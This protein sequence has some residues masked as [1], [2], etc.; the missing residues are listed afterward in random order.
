M[1]P[2]NTDRL[3]AVRDELE[4]D[5]EVRTELIVGSL[6]EAF[7]PLMHADPDG[8][9]AKFRKMAA[10]PFAFYRGSAACSTRTW[11]G[12]TTRGSTSEVAR[13]W[14]Q[15]DLHA[16][17][18]GTY[19]D[20][21]AGS[22]STSTTSTRPTSATGPGTCNG[23]RRAWPCSLAQG[24]ARRGDRRAVGSTPAAYLDQVQYFVETPDD[25]RGR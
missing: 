16:E 10:D 19:L 11:H 23:S 18:F 15:G 1:G 24:A 13:I 20:S 14:I 22:S 7:E 4:S 12:W 5:D 3:A 6:T 21:T 8:F 17:N 25:T 9:R 2:V